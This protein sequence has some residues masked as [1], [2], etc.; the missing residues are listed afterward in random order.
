M[1][2]PEEATRKTA[3]ALSWERAIKIMAL[4]KIKFEPLITH[5]FPLDRWEEGF[6][7]CENKTGVKVILRP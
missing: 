6:S 3:G 5:E 4:G 7:I 2:Y 1:G